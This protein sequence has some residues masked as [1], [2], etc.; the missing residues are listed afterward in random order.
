MLIGYVGIRLLN[1]FPRGQLIF[2]SLEPGG[3]EGS[4][5]FRVLQVPNPVGHA[6]TWLSRDR[7]LPRRGK[8]ESLRRTRFSI[9]DASSRL[10]LFLFSFYFFLTGLVSEDQ[11]RAFASTAVGQRSEN[12]LI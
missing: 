1:N 3:S 8:K 2:F 9:F 6:C 10:L 4:S 7:L 5:E 11:A 12:K